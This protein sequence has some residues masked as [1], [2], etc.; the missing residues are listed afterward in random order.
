M[1]DLG[2]SFDAAEPRSELSKMERELERA[3]KE[4]DEAEEVLQQLELSLAELG[5]RQAI[6]SSDGER[7]V[8]EMQHLREQHQQWWEQALFLK[9]SLSPWAARTIPARIAPR[10]W[11]G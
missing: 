11:S 9:G 7:L 8:K 4:K 3:E 10:R 2:I 6:L 1:A 5:K